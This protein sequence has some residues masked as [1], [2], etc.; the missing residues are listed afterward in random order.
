MRS[1]GLTN[2]I[3]RDNFEDSNT[4]PFDDMVMLASERTWD[5]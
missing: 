5:R 4:R 1:K 3:G 2:R